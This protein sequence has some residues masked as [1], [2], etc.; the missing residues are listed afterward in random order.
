MCYTETNISS[1]TDRR[2]DTHEF[3]IKFKSAKI[4]HF[5]YAVCMY[6]ICSV[7]VIR[8]FTTDMIIAV[9]KYTCTYTHTYRDRQGAKGFNITC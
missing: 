8:V 5:I 3:H 1:L 6:E 7:A 2:T 9:L 4:I